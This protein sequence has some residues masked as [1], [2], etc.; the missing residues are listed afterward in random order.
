MLCRSMQELGGSVTL[1]RSGSQVEDE[2]K[3]SKNRS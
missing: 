2:E 1:D 3:K